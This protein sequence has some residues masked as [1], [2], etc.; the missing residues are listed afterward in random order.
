MYPIHLIDVLLCYCTLLLITSW[1]VYMYMTCWFYAHV[2][3]AITTLLLTL[4]MYMCRYYPID[5]A[6]VH[7][8]ILPYWLYWLSTWLC[9]S[10]SDRITLWSRTWF[11]PLIWLVVPYTQITWKTMSLSFPS[12]LIWSTIFW[13]ISEQSLSTCLFPRKPEH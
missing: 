6:H 12:E 11:E 7:V 9:L 10:V 13:D 2:H 5:S 3:H 8:L 1:N 4:H